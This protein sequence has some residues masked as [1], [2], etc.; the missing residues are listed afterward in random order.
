MYSAH[1]TAVNMKSTDAR[2]G[3][4]GG[5]VA[6]WNL[7]TCGMSETQSPPTAGRLQVLRAVTPGATVRRV[8]RALGLTAGGVHYHLRAARAAGLATTDGQPGGWRLT[9]RG[10]RVLRAL[11]QV[12]L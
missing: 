12:G 6:C 1:Y 9:P 4:R 2:R 3:R 11:G 7:Y 10:E 5:C 8:A